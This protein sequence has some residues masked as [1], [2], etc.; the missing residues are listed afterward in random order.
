M[1]LKQELWK[2]KEKEHKAKSLAKTVK[3]GKNE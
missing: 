2:Q 1:K 3:D